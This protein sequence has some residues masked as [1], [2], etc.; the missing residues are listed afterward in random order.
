[1]PES[2]PVPALM[3]EPGAASAAAA[4]TAASDGGRDRWGDADRLPRLA[5]ELGYPAGALGRLVEAFTH[6]SYSNEAPG[7]PP[8]NERLEYLGDAVLGMLIAEALMQ[9]HTALPEGELS[10]LRAS[11]VNARSLAELGVELDLGAALRLGKGETRSGGRR[12][13]TL[14]ADAYEAMIAAVYLDL[15]LDAARAVVHRHF[16]ARLPRTTPRLDDRDFKTR[17]QE[18]IQ[19]DTGR[20]PVYTVVEAT[21]PD[22]ARAYR[23]EVR[24]GDRLLGEGEGRSKKRA[25]RAAAREAYIALTGEAGEAIE[26]DGEE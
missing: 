5:V 13:E 8:Y 10:R 6:K 7:H 12:K 16:A 9:R 22:H 11:L 25:E 23:V 20:P 21:G 17:V 18:L 4:A 26:G 3:P 15:G 1:M 14:I 19:R 24:A 2:E